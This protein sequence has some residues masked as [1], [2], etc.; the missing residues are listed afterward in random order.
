M[1][2]WY[3]VQ[4]CGDGS[5]YPSFMESEA[6]AELDQKWMDE[7][8]GESCTG[9]I[10]I[11]SDSPITVNGIVTVDEQITTLESDLN[12]DYMEEYETEGKYPDWFKRLRGHIADLKALKGATEPKKRKAKK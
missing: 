11:E 2:I 1:Q 4:N 3:S 8:W 5:A 9:Y 7:G 12:E 10:E 6:Q